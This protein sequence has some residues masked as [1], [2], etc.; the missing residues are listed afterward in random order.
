MN[1]EVRS[2]CN[3]ACFAL[4]LISAYRFVVDRSA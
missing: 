2:R 4:V 3:A 1:L